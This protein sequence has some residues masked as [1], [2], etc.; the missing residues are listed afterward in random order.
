MEKYRYKSQCTLNLASGA[1]KASNSVGEDSNWCSSARSV[2]LLTV[3]GLST[4]A[5]QYW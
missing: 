2:A 4:L 1:L 3:A 5:D